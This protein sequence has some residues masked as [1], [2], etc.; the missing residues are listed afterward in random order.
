MTAAEKKDENKFII[1]IL[2]IVFPVCFIFFLQSTVNRQGRK[3]LMAFLINA[4]LKWN[5][6]N[7]K[8]NEWRYAHTSCTDVVRVLNKN[9]Y[10]LSFGR[11]REV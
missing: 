4:K 7:S 6:L 2:K 5:I 10:A 8:Q 9:L 1:F 3:N 11:I